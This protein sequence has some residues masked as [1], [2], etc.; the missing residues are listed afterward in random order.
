MLWLLLI[1]VGGQKSIRI[2]STSISRRGEGCCFD[3]L[4]HPAGWQ[5]A[6]AW[7]SGG[8]DGLWAPLQA[9][10]DGLVAWKR[11]RNPLRY[12]EEAHSRHPDLDPIARLAEVLQDLGQLS[13]A[14]LQRS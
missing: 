3:V 4:E 14:R 1:P 12:L 2:R 13:R 8:L 6:G 10:P 9:L 7:R 5:L 11:R